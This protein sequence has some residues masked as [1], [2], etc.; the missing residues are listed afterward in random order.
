MRHFDSRYELCKHGVR[1]Y[2]SAQ[3]V[4]KDV[5]RHVDIPMP[6]SYTARTRTREQPSLNMHFEH[7]GRSLFSL[8][9]TLRMC[10]AWFCAPFPAFFR[11]CLCMVFYDPKTQHHTLPHMAIWAVCRLRRL[12]DASS[13]DERAW[14]LCPP[15]ALAKAA[16]SR[17]Y[18]YIDVRFNRTQ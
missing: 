3:L 15:R 12:D 6:A 13:Q 1:R 8:A 11:G 18:I 9:Y 17:S 5:T 14:R 7:V 10:Y 4:M 16:G 2:T